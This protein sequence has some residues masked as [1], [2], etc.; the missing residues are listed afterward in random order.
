MP[1]WTVSMLSGLPNSFYRGV[2]IELAI[3]G[4]LFERFLQQRNAML[5]IKGVRGYDVVRNGSG[6]FAKHVGNDSIKG[7]IANSE[8]ILIAVFFAGFAGNQLETIPHEL[9]QDAD[10]FAGD[11]TAGNKPDSE[12]VADPLGTFRVVLVS[13]DGLDL[14]GVCYGDVDGILQKVEHGNPILPGRFRHPSSYSPKA[15]P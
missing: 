15:R 7:Y 4:F 11:E 12:Q 8:H 5:R 14:L 13:F 9:P 10:V 3:C 6:R 1:S 2:Q